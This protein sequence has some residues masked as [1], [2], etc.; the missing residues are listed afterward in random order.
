MRHIRALRRH[1]HLLLAA[2][3]LAVG[4]VNILFGLNVL[5]GGLVDGPLA[6]F[7]EGLTEG[8]AAFGRSGQ[9][10]FGVALVLLAGGLALRL[11]SAWA[12]STLCLIAL[13][14][15]NLLRGDRHEA[16]V[17]GAPVLLILAVLV[18]FRNAF[19]RQEIGAN[20]IIAAISL[21][22]VLGF[23]TLGTY[24]LGQGFTP[25]VAD[26]PTAL[27]FSVMTLATVGYGDIVPV[28]PTTRMFTVTFLVFGLGIFATALTTLFSSTVEPRLQRV[29]APKSSG[30]ARHGR[31]ILVG[32][33]P[34]ANSTA[35]E[36]ERRKQ[37][38]VRL[39]AVGPGGPAPDAASGRPSEVSDLQRA[40][41]ARA[42][43]VILAG[44]DVADNE[45]AVAA[46]KLLA[47]DVRVL[48]L[49]APEHFARLRRAKADLLFAPTAAA[50]RLV[51][52][53]AEGEP[54]EP[55]MRDLV[56]GELP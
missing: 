29:L 15:A 1:A 37:E 20:I 6:Q 46:V 5:G 2:L 18:L 25:V 47:P 12:F 36:F 21:A 54:L 7:D 3:I 10:G 41:V 28:T 53:L 43:L 52:Q 16:L 56:V 45:R 30:A 26:L 33:G 42:R 49:A 51:A 27:Y 39:S 32:Q 50:G 23:A 55:S 44:D 38:F 22:A 48:A 24:L 14:A 31:V 34:L 8:F 9:L 4:A 35:A 40:G 11:R 19:D 17:L 13:L